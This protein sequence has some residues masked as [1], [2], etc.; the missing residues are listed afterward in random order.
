MPEKQNRQLASSA[1]RLAAIL[2]ADIAGYTALMQKDEADR[3]YPALSFS[4]K[5]RR[6]NSAQMRLKIQITKNS[7][8]S[9][10]DQFN[11]LKNYFFTFSHSYVSPLSK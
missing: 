4:K 1:R 10:N 3:P 11:L 6:I 8:S 7:K 9:S 5:H 2:F